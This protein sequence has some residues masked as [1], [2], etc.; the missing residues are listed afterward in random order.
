MNTSEQQPGIRIT[1]TFNVNT[2]QGREQRQEH[3]IFGLFDLWKIAEIIRFG[4]PDSARA[5][6]VFAVIVAKMDPAVEYPFPTPGEHAKLA[7]AIDLL[8]EMCRRQWEEKEDRVL[9]FTYE[10]LRR[11]YIGRELAAFFASATLGK[12]Y[13]TDAW[14]VKLDRWTERQDP[15]LP[16]VG[17][18]RGRPAQHPQTKARKKKARGRPQP[19]HS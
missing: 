17:M 9:D 4:G 12:H 15:K 1:I 8:W 13:T 19:E 6:A 10:L 7:G 14:R 18:P 5:F 2:D 16:K 11:Q 3:L